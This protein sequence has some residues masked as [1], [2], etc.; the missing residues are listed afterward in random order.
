LVEPVFEGPVVE[1]G[2]PVPVEPGEHECGH[3]GDPRAVDAANGERG[4]LGLV[5]REATQRDVP[6]AEGD[7]PD[8]QAA[9]ARP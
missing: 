8:G 5:N 1:S 4:P 9:P 2:G 3:G 7:L 6:A